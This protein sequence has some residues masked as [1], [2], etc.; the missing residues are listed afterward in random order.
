MSEVQDCDLKDD[1]V[2]KII[3]DVDFITNKGYEPV[4]PENSPV[5]LSWS[6]LTVKMEF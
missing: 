1:I 4:S 5:C 2:I 6:N 3:N